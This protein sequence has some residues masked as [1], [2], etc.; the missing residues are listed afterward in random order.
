MRPLRDCHDDWN[1]APRQIS[2][3]ASSRPWRR[4]RLLARLHPSPNLLQPH[5]IPLGKRH[6]HL[7]LPAERAQIVAQRRKLH[8]R[9]VFQAR[10]VDLPSADA[11][12]HLGLR[13]AARL[14]DVGEPEFFRDQVSRPRFDAC[15][16]LLGR[17]GEQFF[18]RDWFVR[19][20]DCSTATS[21]RPDAR[22]NGQP[23]F[24]SSSGLSTPC[25]AKIAPR[26]RRVCK[27]RMIVTVSRPVM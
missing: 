4:L 12:G 14:A 10:D 20:T 21:L 25:S 1:F 7:Q 24:Q 26:S 18:R 9:A 27:T 23:L 17:R 5:A 3:C 11:L 2:P 8:G 13:E 16:P 6:H 19:V 22:Q 15:A